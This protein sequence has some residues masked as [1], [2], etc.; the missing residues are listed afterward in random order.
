MVHK[1]ADNVNAATELSFEEADGL[2]KIYSN[3]MAEITQPLVA[4]MYSQKQ[5]ASGVSAPEDMLQYLTD[6]EISDKCAFLRRNYPNRAL[7]FTVW[8]IVG[9]LPVSHRPTIKG[10]GPLSYV[11]IVRR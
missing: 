10:G 1:F 11:T 6:Q 3:K 5:L 2:G 4:T 7:W 9:R 8:T